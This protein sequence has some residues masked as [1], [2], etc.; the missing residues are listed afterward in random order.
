[1]WI[2]NDVAVA[3][4]ETLEL[5]VTEV[6]WKVELSADQLHVRLGMADVHVRVLAGTD[7]GP[8]VSFVE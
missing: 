6:P 4:E 2:L 1:V 8:T 3:L 5:L 7:G